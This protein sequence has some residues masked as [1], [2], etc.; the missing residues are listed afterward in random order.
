LSNLLKGGWVEVNSDEKRIIDTNELVN[1][2]LT[3]LSQP[4]RRASH[5]TLGEPDEE[6]F[7]GGVQAEILDGLTGDD[8]NGIPTVIH[9]EPVP[10][11][12]SLEDTQKQVDQMLADAQAQVD[13]ARQEADNIRAAAAKDA[14]T[15]RENARQE[16]TQQGYQDGIAQAEQECS[17]RMA[18]LDQKQ[19]ELETAYETRIQDL[20][21]QFIDTLTGIY[22]HIFHVELQGYRDILFYLIT[23]T[24]RKIEGNRSFFI[25]VSKEDYPFVSMQ[26]KQIAASVAAGS[27]IEVV[28]DLTLSKNQCMIETEDGIFD[29]G[30]STQLTELSNRLKLLSYEKE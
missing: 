11:G 3:G 28:E 9:Q 29:C 7:A 16:G 25:H 27:S 8:E 20:E 23:N 1:K 18:E 17:Q 15:I 10:T 14:E 4:V 21:P 12:P 24:M 30:V 5:T 6:G 13:A 22:E 26:K 2:R 19:K